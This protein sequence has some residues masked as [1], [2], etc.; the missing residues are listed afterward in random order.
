MDRMVLV[1]DL[2]AIRCAKEDEDAQRLSDHGG[3][4]VRDI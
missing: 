3:E 1:N 4:V 2:K